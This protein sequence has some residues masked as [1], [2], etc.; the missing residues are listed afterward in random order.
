MKIFCSTDKLSISK[1]IYNNENIKSIEHIGEGRFSSY[2]TMNINYPPMVSLQKQIENKYN[3]KLITRGEAH[4]TVVTPLEFFDIL[5]EKVSMKE[6]NLIAKKSL[7]QRT[8]F[9]IIC[10]GKGS[11]NIKNKAEETYYIVVKSNELKSIRQKVKRLFVKRGGS[12][13]SFNPKKYYPH[14]TIGF[15]KRDLHE[16]D[17]IIKN[18]DSCVN[19]I[20]IN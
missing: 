16:S 2:L 11:I 7:V 13:E 19:D 14:I 3:V 1:S 15:T 8:S 10:L 12:K 18:S 9:N 4:I 5:K 6:I 20:L 17:G